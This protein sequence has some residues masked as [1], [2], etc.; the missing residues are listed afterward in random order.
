MKVKAILELTLDLEYLLRIMTSDTNTA[1]FNKIE[2]FIFDMDGT[3]ALRWKIAPRSRISD[4][5][6][7]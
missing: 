4:K 2:C 7:A 5:L 1:R 3:I 6:P